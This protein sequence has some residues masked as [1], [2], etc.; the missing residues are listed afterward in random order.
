MPTIPINL[1]DVEAYKDLD[2]GTYLCEIQKVVH[3]EPK[4]EGSYP[5]LRIHYAV[6]DG[7]NLGDRTTEW[8][9]LSPNAAWRLKKWFMH[10]G[11]DDL[12]NLEIDEDSEELTEPDLVG[13]RVIVEVKKDSSS[14][15]GFRT[16]LISVEDDMSETVEAPAPKRAKAAPAPAADAEEVEDEEDDEEEEKPAPKR[17]APAARPAAAQRRSLR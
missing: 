12:E 14:P 11:Y 16:S 7:D 15:S 8:V 17:A 10:F 2:V 3:Q 6:I 4:K 5:Q 9:S 1:G 13:V